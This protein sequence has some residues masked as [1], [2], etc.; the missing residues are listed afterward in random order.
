MKELELLKN[1][2][3]EME[4]KIDDLEDENARLNYKIEMQ[5]ITRKENLIKNFNHYEKE[6]LGYI[7]NIQNDFLY[8]DED[9]CKILLGREEDELM[10]NFAKHLIGFINKNNIKKYFDYDEYIK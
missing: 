8:N 7:E 2:I 5:N 1:K 9:V 3:E 4:K 6:L 10:E